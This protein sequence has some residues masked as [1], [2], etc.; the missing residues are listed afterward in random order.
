MFTL[1]YARINGWVNNCEAGD[2]RRYHTHYDVIVMHISLTFPANKTFCHSSPP[3]TLMIPRFQPMFSPPRTV[4]F[5]G[6]SPVSLL[7]CRLYSASTASFGFLYIITHLSN[8]PSFFGKW[9]VLMTRTV[10]SLVPSPGNPLVFNGL[11]LYTD[12]VRIPVR[13]HNFMRFHVFFDLRPNKWLSKYCDLRRYRAHHGC[14]DFDET[15]IDF[16]C[17]YQFTAF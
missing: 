9:C 12:P 16:S 4:I 17:S 8:F 1:I 15:E 7:C 5:F 13:I 2:L 6:R 10:P 3:S 11:V 14:N